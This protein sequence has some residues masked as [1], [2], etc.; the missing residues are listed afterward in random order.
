MLINILTMLPD[1]SRPW[2]SCLKPNVDNFRLSE[3]NY[4]KYIKSL[5]W[6]E[7]LKVSFSKIYS[8]KNSKT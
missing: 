6:C 5:L 2:D 8:S 3:T 7:E 4:T 1:V